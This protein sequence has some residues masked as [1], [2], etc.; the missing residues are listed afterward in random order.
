MPDPALVVLVG[1]SGSGKSTWAAEHYRATEIVSSDALRAVVGSGP[2]DLDAS[3][4]AFAVLESVVAARA[5]RGLTTVI[6]TLGLDAVRRAGL[7]RAGPGARP[8][9]RRRPVRDPGRGLPGPQPGA[10]PAGAGGR[11]D[12][13]GQGRCG[14]ARTQL[15]A[16]GWDLM[17][18]VG[19]PSTPAPRRDRER[20]PAARRLRRP[21]RRRQPGR[22]GVRAAGLPVP[23]GRGPGR[24]ADVG[25]PG[26]AGGRLRGHRADGP[27]DP[28]PAGRPRVGGPAGAVRHP[29]PAR[30][31]RS[32][33]A[34]RA[35][36]SRRSRCGRRACW[37]RPSPRSTSCPAAGRSAASGP[38]GGSA[39][40][41]RTALPFA[42]PR[43][44]AGPARGRHRGDAGAVAAGHRGVLRGV[45]R[46]AGDHVL[47]AAGRAGAG[48]RR[49]SRA[50]AAGHR[51][52]GSATRA[53]CRRTR[54][55]SSRG[56]SGCGLRCEEAGRDPAEVAVTVLD[57]PVVGRDRE[58]TAQRVER[59]RGRTS[60]AA[61]ARAHH[62]GPAAEH[63]ERY[64]GG[65]PSS[66]S[67]TVFV[68]LPGPGRAGRP[69]AARPGRRG[70]RELDVSATVASE[71]LEGADQPAAVDLAAG[72]A[73]TR[74][75]STLGAASR[76][77]VVV[78]STKSSTVARSRSS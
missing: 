13:P 21:T 11:A 6:D 30:R 26:R 65:W 49:R 58:D 46:A 3:A 8:A 56:S 1:P 67:S 9:G 37:P 57:V 69:G 28:D 66:G 7:A 74:S 60:A 27:P 43:R 19:R 75:W 4:D 55:C 35:R 77:E 12:R 61:Y 31:R 2:D 47:P 59:L 73:A 52:R 45:G 44:A 42:P 14:V 20:R 33:A 71:G 51:R 64:S 63:V 68:A 16:E 5:G 34:A 24:L 40:T 22:L 17:L 25:G 23:L 36:W 18:V 39:S 29:R 53:T 50:A 78:W 72:S 62:A 10:G 41:R 15:E 32:R 70:V 76:L 48:H 38:A 54:P